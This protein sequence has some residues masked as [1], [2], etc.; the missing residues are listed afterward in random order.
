MTTVIR[1]HN[2]PIQI[3]SRLCS[4]LIH[5]L[6]GSTLVFDDLR[7]LGGVRE[8]LEYCSQEFAFPSTTDENEG[9]EVRG[10]IVGLDIIIKELQEGKRIEVS[11]ISANEWE[12][13]EK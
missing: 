7:R 11:S 5:D 1:I 6:H 2:L 3:S 13:M 12:Q 10:M 8:A 4:F 9:E